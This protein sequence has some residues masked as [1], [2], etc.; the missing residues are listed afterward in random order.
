MLS[1]LS[2]V[3]SARHCQHV[4]EAGHDEQRASLL[5]QAAREEGETIEEPRDQIWTA[6]KH[7]RQGGGLEDYCGEG[8]Q[9]GELVHITEKGVER[10]HQAPKGFIRV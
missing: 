7:F 8:V 4:E 3:Q 2:E 9:T 6:R 10:L 1:S 5:V